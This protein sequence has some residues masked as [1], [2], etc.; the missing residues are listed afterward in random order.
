[1]SVTALRLAIYFLKGG[2]FQID[3]MFCF[4]SRGKP[5]AVSTVF[6]RGDR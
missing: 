1:M 3:L 2:C 6:F 5:I 4:Y